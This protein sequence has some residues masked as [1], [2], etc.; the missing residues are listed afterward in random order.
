M[1]TVHMGKLRPSVITFQLYSLVGV[2]LK[3][4][5]LG[6]E[7]SILFLYKVVIILSIY[8]GKFIFIYEVRTTILKM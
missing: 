7:A 8:P 3:D 5:N 4:W 6:L 1:L 2:R